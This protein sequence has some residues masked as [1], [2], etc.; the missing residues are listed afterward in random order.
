MCTPAAGLFG[1]SKVR[2]KLAKKGFLGVAGERLEDKNTEF[3]NA[4]Q[5]KPSPTAMSGDKLK[6]K[7]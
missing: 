2:T 6:I 7:Y 3:K 1:D 5:P 4:N